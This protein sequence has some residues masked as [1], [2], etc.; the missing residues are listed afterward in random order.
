MTPGLPVF[1]FFFPS[2]SP[3]LLIILIQNLKQ[4]VAKIC[5]AYDELVI[6]KQKYQFELVLM[7]KIY[8]A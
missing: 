7:S 3:N 6:S 1:F 4:L 2:P 5:N 8:A